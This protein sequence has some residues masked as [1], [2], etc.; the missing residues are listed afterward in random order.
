MS[1]LCPHDSS[2]LGIREAEGHIGYL[3]K[4]CR[5]LWLP[6]KYIQSLEHLRKFSPEAFYQRLAAQPK[7]RSTIKCPGGCGE[8]HT[9]SIKGIDLDYC[10]ACHGIWFDRGEAEVLLAHYP[11]KGPDNSK[12]LD[13]FDIADI[14]ASLLDWLQ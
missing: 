12:S 13:S 2:E 7:F 6:P 8:L 4:S 10:P 3:C 1:L 11:I 9:K 14:G 5:G